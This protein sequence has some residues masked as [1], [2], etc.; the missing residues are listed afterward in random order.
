VYSVSGE[1]FTIDSWGFPWL[2][3]T[4][5]LHTAGVDLMTIPSECSVVKTNGPSIRPSRK[6]R[7]GNS[8]WFTVSFVP[9][10]PSERSFVVYNELTICMRIRLTERIKQMKPEV[11]DKE[12][13][14]H[15][16]WKTLMHGRDTIHRESR[17]RQATNIWGERRVLIEIHIDHN[18]SKMADKMA[19]DWKLDG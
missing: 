7:S 2:M 5:P 13:R 16:S 8:S 10:D 12:Q 3:L 15:G 4:C 9:T 17:T 6:S 18:N 1:T 11:T 14:G 19:D